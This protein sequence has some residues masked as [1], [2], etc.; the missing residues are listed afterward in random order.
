MSR[1][2][3]HDHPDT[4][5]HETRVIDARPGAVVARADPRPSTPGVVLI[6]LGS[7]LLTDAGYGP[8]TPNSGDT[9]LKS[10]VPPE[11]FVLRGRSRYFAIYTRC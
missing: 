7:R 1:Y 10:Q 2:F 9:G 5:T 3:C 11:G 6:E 4:L 8:F